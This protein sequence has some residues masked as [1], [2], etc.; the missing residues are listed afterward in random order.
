[1]ISQL[2]KGWM[3][4]GLLSRRGIIS[5]ERHVILPVG[6]DNGCMDHTSITH[7]IEELE[8]SDAATAVELADELAALLADLLDPQREVAD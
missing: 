2:T 4:V 6:G 3:T 5:I 8:Q 7:S 1:M